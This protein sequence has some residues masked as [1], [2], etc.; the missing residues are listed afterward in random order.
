[1]NRPEPTD[2]L[3]F[4]FDDEPINVD[5]LPELVRLQIHNLTFSSG[6]RVD[7]SQ[8]SSP[9]QEKEGGTETSF[10][11]VKLRDKRAVKVTYK[12]YPILPEPDELSKEIDASF[13]AVFDCLLPDESGE[14]LI[15]I[16]DEVI[17]SAVTALGQDKIFLLTGYS[18]SLSSTLRSTVCD[19]NRMEK[20]G[21]VV[22]L[23][24]ALAELIIE[25]L[26]L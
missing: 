22:K 16:E 26:G 23:A 3:I 10:F 18:E 6:R 2:I 20:P 24:E 9:P 7:L 4:H 8:L 11:T 15:P 14:D 17:T 1:M 21:D 25:E 12:I 5:F 13:C 19:G